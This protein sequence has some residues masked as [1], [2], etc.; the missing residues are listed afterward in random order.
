MVVEACVTT[1][2]EAIQAADAG[3]DRLELCVNLPAGGLSPPTRLL[4]EVKLATNV[5]VVAMIR[6]RSGPFQIPTPDWPT[7]LH[8][9]ESL[10]L[11][12]ADGFVFGALSA[13]GQVDD[14]ILARVMD[15]AAEKPVTFHRA[16]DQAEDL[17]RAL[18]V[19][20]AAGVTRVLTAGGPGRAWDGRPTLREL[21]NQG[22]PRIT[23]MAG[24]GVRGDHVLDLVSDT[25]VQQVHARSIAIPGIVHALTS[26]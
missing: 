8:R 15:A 5:P 12:G 4:E 10:H 7:L 24:G 14:A 18:E 17:H 1:V 23:I 20:L 9:I 13:D 22:G 11:A 16:F 26:T 2:N 19:L 6:E 21:V 25:G 3:A